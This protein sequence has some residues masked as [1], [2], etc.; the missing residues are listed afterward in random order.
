[1]APPY[2][3]SLQAERDSPRTVPFI[4]LLHLSTAVAASSLYSSSILL[5]TLFLAISSA[6]HFSL[7]WTLRVLYYYVV[8][9]WIYNFLS[10]SIDLHVSDLF[11]PQ[12]F[13]F[14]NRRQF[15]LF[16]FV[17]F[18]SWLSSSSF[19]HFLLLPSILYLDFYGL[20]NICRIK[21]GVNAICSITTWLLYLIVL[22]N[23]SLTAVEVVKTGFIQ[24]TL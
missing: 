9:L 1:M 12:L 4:C 13:K 5:S 23:Q 24:E 22:K 11:L 21:E 19:P 16:I 10:G 8:F 17:L 3:P 18:P 14:A 15:Y 7:L 6:Y 20:I 2:S